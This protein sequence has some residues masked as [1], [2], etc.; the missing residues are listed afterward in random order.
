MQGTKSSPCQSTMK[1]YLVLICL[2]SVFLTGWFWEQKVYN[3]YYQYAVWDLFDEAAAYI[4]DSE[5]GK[6]VSFEKYRAYKAV[7][8]LARR[9]GGMKP[10]KLDREL[11]ALGLDLPD[12]FL[13]EPPTEEQL[14]D[15]RRAVERMKTGEKGGQARL[16]PSEQGGQARLL[17]SEQGGQAF[18]KP[19]PP[20]AR[21]GKTLSDWETYLNKYSK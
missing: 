18:Q 11:M 20:I 1:K 19:K 17:P 6:P 10:E 14:E 16:P 12:L 15:V 2:F 21:S 7:D 9:A 4:H 5:L 3:P 13:S 8:T